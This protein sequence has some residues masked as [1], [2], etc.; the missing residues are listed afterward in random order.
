[1][2]GIAHYAYVEMPQNQHLVPLF[3]ELYGY[4]LLRHGYCVEDLTEYL[5]TPIPVYTEKAMKMLGASIYD[6]DTA[7]YNDS[8][9]K[10]AVFPEITGVGFNCPCNMDPNVKHEYNLAFV[11]CVLPSKYAVPVNV[12][13]VKLIRSVIEV[14]D[15]F[16]FGINSDAFICIPSIGYI[17]K[18][19]PPPA[20]EPVI[21]P[22]GIAN[23]QPI[24]KLYYYKLKETR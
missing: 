22:L 2:N 18:L 1:M 24:N 4:K 8:Y 12:G 9:A 7:F 20:T 15:C 16:I 21:A 17:S 5:Q 6:G 10:Y 11:D 23:G 14:W 3:K 19:S 13:G